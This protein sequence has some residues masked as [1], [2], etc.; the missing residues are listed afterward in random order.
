MCLVA[1]KKIWLGYV[2]NARKTYGSITDVRQPK[3]SETICINAESEPRI[4]KEQLVKGFTKYKR[5]I[6]SD[7]DM[8]NINSQ[9]LLIAK[10]Q[11]K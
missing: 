2:K 4:T 3:K 9:E 10:T 8:G 7:C 5:R 11:G 1:S 6:A